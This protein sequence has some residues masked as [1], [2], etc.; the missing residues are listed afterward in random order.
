VNRRQ[1]ASMEL[2]AAPSP[3]VSDAGPLFL[4]PQLA[5]VT[6]TSVAPAQLVS[7]FS[8][9]EASQCRFL[10]GLLSCTWVVQ[11]RCIAS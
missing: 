10:T 6:R 5:Q 8:V 4:P 9:G 11:A 1:G 7:F 2:V 3:G